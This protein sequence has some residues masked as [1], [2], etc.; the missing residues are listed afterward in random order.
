MQILTSFPDT[1]EKFTARFPDEEACIAFLYH[2]RFPDGFSCPYCRFKIQLKEIKKSIPCPRCGNTTSL[3]SGTIMHGTKKPLCQ[4]LL[5]IWWLCT[6]ESGA[7]AKE[8]QRVLKLSS[9]QT[10]W[11]WLQKFR[12]AMGAADTSLCKGVVE[13]GCS[14]VHPAREKKDKAMV[15]G[16]AEVIIPAGITGRVRMASFT[17]CT[18]DNIN[19]FLV[20][21]VKPGSTLITSNEEHF[22]TVAQNDYTHV[23][24]SANR[25]TERVLDL[26]AGF[27]IWLNTLHR[28]GV[29]VKHL[30]LYLDEFCFRNNASMLAD[31]PAM[32]MALL[33]G[34][35]AKKPTPYKQ[36][37][38]ANARE[39]R[40]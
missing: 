32:F 3:T 4:W 24:E 12:M 35:M 15:L 29:A 34:V 8:L 39:Q 37:V 10:A 36:L 7:T 9:Y 6:H 31:R 20:T 26:I 13:I 38:S 14:F 30:Q 25:E 23:I 11:A 21:A 27:E 2:V 17:H 33:R 19:H 22:Q 5:A 40:S 16:A 28:G 18:S 1:V